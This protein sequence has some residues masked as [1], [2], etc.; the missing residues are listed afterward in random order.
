M[1]MH[2]QRTLS[3]TQQQAWDAL[4]NPEILKA[5]IPGCEKFDVTEENQ[6]AVGTAIKIGPVAARFGGKVQLSDINPPSSYTLNFDAQGG[7]AGFGKGESKVQLEPVDGGCE[8][9]YTVNSTVGG[10]IAQLGQRLIDGAA[11]SLADDFFKR[12]DA[13]LKRLYPPA[14]VEAPAAGA[15]PAQAAVVETAAPA[16]SSGGG[17][18]ELVGAFVGGAVVALLVWLVLH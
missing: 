10:K 12:F 17:I 16:D 8:L 15:A 6:Y 4:N 1:E 18:A 7:V 5:C 3:C 9:K 13:E 11:K 14:E 2:G